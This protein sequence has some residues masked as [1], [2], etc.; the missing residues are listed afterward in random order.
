MFDRIKTVYSHHNIVIVE[1][2]RDKLSLFSTSDVVGNPG[3]VRSKLS[4]NSLYSV[5]KS[6]E[7]KRYFVEIKINDTSLT[8]NFYQLAIIQNEEFAETDSRINDPIEC[9][10]HLK[11]LLKNRIPK[12]KSS[13]KNA[14]K[15][16]T[17]PNEFQLVGKR[18]IYARFAHMKNVQ[19]QKFM[20]PYNA[21]VAAH[22]LTTTTTK[23]NIELEEL[24]KSLVESRSQTRDNVDRD[25]SRIMKFDSL[26]ANHVVYTGKQMIFENIARK[27]QPILM[28][29]DDLKFNHLSAKKMTVSSNIINNI[30]L[31]DLYSATRTKMIP[32]MKKFKKLKIGEL[33]IGESLNAVPI[34]FLNRNESKI[35]STE[36]INFKG[37][38]NVQHLKVRFLN[39]FNVSTLLDEVCL[40]STRNTI[41]GDLIVRNALNVKHLVANRINTIPINNFMTTSTDQIIESDLMINKFFATNLFANLINN[42]DLRN[43]A[44]SSEPNVIEIPTKFMTINVLKNLNIED[45]VD[46]D[47]SRAGGAKSFVDLVKRHVIGT[48]T[49]DLAQIYNGKVLIRGNLKL[50]NV[51]TSSLKSKIYVNENEVPQ[52]IAENYWMKTLKQTIDVENF[53]I[54]EKNDVT[55][56]NGIVT[57][58]INEH[59][60]D[61]FLLLDSDQPQGSLN[62]K[63]LNAIVDG[64]VKG[65]KNNVPSQIYEISK[66]AIVRNGEAIEMSSPIEFRGTL[67]V[68]NLHTNTIN[69]FSTNNFIRKFQPVVQITAPKVIENLEVDNMEINNIL[70][71]DKYNNINLNHLVDNAVNV[72]KPIEIE[73]LKLK[74]FRTNKLSVDKFENHPFGDMWNSLSN[75][76]NTASMQAMKKRKRSV[77]ING[78]ASFASNV[79]IDNLN[80]RS[81]DEFLSNLIMKND[82]KK[83]GGKKIFLQDVIVKTDLNSESLNGFSTDRLLYQSL[84]RGDRQT[85]TSNTVLVKNLITHSLHVTDLNGVSG[86]Q[87]VD[88]RRLSERLNVNLNVGEL[89]V[90]DI[91]TSSA[92]SNVDVMMET[93]QFPKRSHWNY[94]T[95]AKDTIMAKDNQASYF[96][97][98]LKFGVRKSLPQI[99]TGTVRIQNTEK[100]FMKKVIKSNP[101]INTRI[102]TANIE[103]LVTDSVKQYSKLEEIR[104]KKT[105]RAGYRFDANNLIIGPHSSFYSPFVND[106]NVTDLNDSIYRTS[107]VLH[108]EKNFDKDLFV[109]QLY[110]VEPGRING[111]QPS[112]IIYTS[113]TNLVLPILLVNNL[114]VKNMITY[115]F[116][117]NSLKYFMENR[118]KKF[119][120]DVQQVSSFIKFNSMHFEDDAQLTTINS[121]QIDDAV[122]S[123]S[124]S[125]QIISGRKILTGYIHVIGKYN[126]NVN[127]F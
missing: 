124:N 95:V 52:N 32:G 68:K 3:L 78:N 51:N 110:I 53:E 96:D 125:L 20:M 85:I 40:K 19:I 27:S 98:L 122:F 93:I 42:E 113:N 77:T 101:Y 1:N 41:N 46:D 50:K 75:E 60:I 118:M 62:I 66:V 105:I 115:A 4:D 108:S 67:N 64:D 76:F 11:A 43:V 39:G 92:T 116:N 84:S 56:A 83:I 21:S 10:L 97:T 99:I 47:H 38:I 29:G 58:M 22:N 91:T 15:L 12:I 6:S 9:V 26:R 2:F 13:E 44:L 111:V 80:E 100:F 87:L 71:V 36:S 104:G 119:S 109:D 24:S 126:E 114:D 70:S 94:V 37:D 103:M 117:S 107:D 81:F 30:N 16:K 65:H 35:Q 121:V 90:N 112:T 14:E 48:K 34:N 102:A 54:N 5:Y 89:D 28:L 61:D 73:A 57:K 17:M 82:A 25:E 88:R 106:V 7:G 72:N 18:N 79:L 123:Y 63:F 55:F 31:N 127:F 45:I 59:S 8:S 74:T 23:N 33:N 49:S 86:D 69:D 120:K